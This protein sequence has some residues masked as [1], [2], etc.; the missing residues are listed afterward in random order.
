LAFNIQ[1]AAEPLST[2]LWEKLSAITQS[3]MEKLG[4]SFDF[5]Q[6]PA[7]VRTQ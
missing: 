7:D 3:L 5:W 4:P 6:N 2:V 1:A